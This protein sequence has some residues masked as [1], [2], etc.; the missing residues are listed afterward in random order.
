MAFCYLEAMILD[1]YLVV[2]MSIAFALTWE[3]AASVKI[4]SMKKAMYISFVSVDITAVLIS[5]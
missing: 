4:S 3:L 1:Q 2:E 5:V